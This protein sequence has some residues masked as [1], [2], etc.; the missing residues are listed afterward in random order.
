M[1]SENDLKLL[2]IGR[3]FWE[4]KNKIIIGENS[5]VKGNIKAEILDVFGQIIGNIIVNKTVYI[6]SHAR[7]KGDIQSQELLTETGSVFNGKLK[8]GQ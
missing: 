1:Q 3:H 4:K 6:R 7:V 8:I 5:L 2:K